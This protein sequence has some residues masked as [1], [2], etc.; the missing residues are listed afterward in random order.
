[1]QII[2]IVEKE[3]KDLKYKIFTQ[4]YEINQMQ[5]QLKNLTLNYEFFEN[6]DYRSKYFTGLDTWQHLKIFYS[7][8]EENLPYNS[9]Y[10]LS[11][12]QTFILTLM[13]LRL[14]H[15]FKELAFRFDISETT[16]SGLFY[17]YLRE[18]YITD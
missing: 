8:I 7:Q 17:S 9:K 5:N 4:N 15:S 13:K 11:K 3:V 1:M 2:Y 6:N 16:A 12:W 10:S 14:N 18:I